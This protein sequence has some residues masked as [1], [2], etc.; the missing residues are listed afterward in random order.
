MKPRA[1]AERQQR[2]LGAA[3]REAHALGARHEV[4]DALGPVGLL[5]A[6]RAEVLTEARL[7]AHRLDD[8][9]MRVAGDHRAVACHVV[10]DAVAVDVPLVGAL[11]AR[12]ARGERILSAG[13]VREAAREELQRPLVLG[14][15]ARVGACVLREGGEGG[16]HAANATAGPARV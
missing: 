13:I 3:G 5:L 7:P 4:D 6:A 11:G 10:E 15:R 12:D 8:G 16:A 9:G 14:L 1:S 2:R